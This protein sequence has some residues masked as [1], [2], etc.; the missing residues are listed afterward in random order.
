MSCIATCIRD[1]KLHV[2]VWRGL[3]PRME[4]MDAA[5]NA[6][7]QVRRH[8]TPGCEQAD[9]RCRPAILSHLPAPMRY[10][11]ACL[12]TYAACLRLVAE[13][14]RRPLSYLPATRGRGGP[15]KPRVIQHGPKGRCARQVRA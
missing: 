2:G 9:L 10:L 8:A 15:D 14:C 1:V 3:W 11:P 13:V 6:N 4:R 7:G 5:A 12:R